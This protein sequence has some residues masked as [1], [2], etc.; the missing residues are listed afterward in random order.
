MKRL[1]ELNHY[2]ILEISPTASQNEIREAYERAKRT[3][4]RDSIGIYSLLDETEIEEMTRLI[5][6]A[7]QAI[8]HEKGRREYD[9]ILVCPEREEIK[10]GGS[11]SYGPLS[12]SATFSPPGEIRNVDPDR[13]EKVEEMISRSGFEYT[14]SVLKEIR[15]ILGLDI[16]EISMKTKVGRT[17]LEFLEAENFAHLPA[18]VYIKGFIGEY[19]KC[20]GLDALRVIEDYVDRYRAWERN[21]DA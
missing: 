8:G 15:E 6:A 17:N 20:L 4:H 19:A 16:R 5:E 7:Y 3:Y 1:E 12:Q 11:S 13:R 2:E 10:E 21:R 18:L 14:G 9:Q